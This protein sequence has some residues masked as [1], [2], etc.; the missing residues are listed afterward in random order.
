MRRNEGEQLMTQDDLFRIIDKLTGKEIQ[1][2][3]VPDD[4]TEP[5]DFIEIMFTDGSSLEICHVS[6]GEISI[7]LR[8]TS[9]AS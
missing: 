8:E 2:A 3:L 1:T 7:E 5:F 4:S 9:N 6:C